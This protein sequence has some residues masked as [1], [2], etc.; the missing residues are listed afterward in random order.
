VLRVTTTANDDGPKPATAARIYDYFLGGTH[1]FPADRQAAQALV[2]AAPMIP[3][4]ARANR[5]FLRRAVGHMV[6]GGVRQFLDIG[7]GI[8]TA[9]N[10]HEV[11]PQTRVVYVDIDPVA[12]AESLDI[13]EGNERATALRADLRDPQS[14]LDNDEVRRL[15]DFSEPVG[16]LM[17][18]M[19][20][21]L[22]D[23]QAY[24]AVS[25][26]VASLAAGSFLGISHGSPNEA[27]EEAGDLEAAQ[28]VMRGRTAT[29]VNPRTRAGIER[30]FTGM[31]I[32]EPGL[33]WVPQWRP[34]ADD[35]TDFADS[36]TLCAVLAGVALK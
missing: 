19:L 13:L 11:A 23:D 31:R 4:I 29:P 26:L 27:I 35:P 20:H 21:F 22:D 28:S 33:V 10:V 1:N 9:G 18:A 6:D 17:V 8:P 30:F 14:I 5:A 36:P 3:K 15:I 34:A 16:L 12:V 24:P 25:R 2:A 32:V 7:S